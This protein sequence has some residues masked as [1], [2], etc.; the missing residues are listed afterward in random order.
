MEPTIFDLSKEEIKNRLLL[1][2]SENKLLE[3]RLFENE[4]NR[5][6]DDG[7]FQRDYTR[8]LYSSSF[9]RLQGKMQLLAIKS[10]QFIRNRLTHSLEVAQIARSIADK[11]GYSQVESYVVETGA[12]AHDIGNPP[13]GHAGERFLNDL[14]KDFGGF[15]GNA[16]TLRILT[17]VEQK[18]GYFQ[19]LNLTYRTLLSVVKY[20]KVYNKNL[21][22]ENFGKQK[23]LYQDDYEFINNI[24]T[25]TNVS[26]RTLDVQIVDLADEIAYAAHDLEDGLRLGIFTEDEILHDFYNY[27]NNKATIDIFEKIL[28]ESKERSSYKTINVDSSEYK[29]LYRKEITSKIINT[30]I[31]DIGIIKIDNK[32]REKTG[33]INMEELG[34]VNYG[35]LASG[36]KDTVYKGITHND[37]VYAY[38]SRGK[39]ML[40]YLFSFYIKHPEYLPSEYRANLIK[41]QYNPKYNDYDSTTLQ[42]RLI[43]DYLSGMMDK[44]VET[45]YDS[46]KDIRI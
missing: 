45:I 24:V 23:F 13:F 41:A 6:R 33:T 15:E 28:D 46:L 8:I 11:I 2:L 18:R 38:E 39:A 14:S 32:S 10:D 40:E 4:E 1:P 35:I 44:Y 34:L 7:E 37:K 29:K 16:Q 21:K 36:L 20:N 9:R 19:G 25:D 17:T 31:S 27:T 5:N 30:L 3:H 42:K 43:I 12:L 22:K 26:V